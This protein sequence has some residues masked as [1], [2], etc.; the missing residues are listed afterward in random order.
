[1]HA[2]S[3]AIGT[4]ATAALMVVAGIAQ[5]QTTANGPYYAIP[6]WDQ[7]LPAAQRFIVLSNWIDTRFPSGGAAVLDR[8]TGL[9]WQRRPEIPP[10]NQG[11][12]FI[13]APSLCFGSFTGGRGGWRLPT[14]E[15]LGTLVDPKQQNPALPLGSPF[16]SIAGAFWT[17]D[18]SA[19]AST[20]VIVDF[21]AGFADDKPKS[22]TLGVWCVRGG[23]H[24][25]PDVLAN[26]PI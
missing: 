9:I 17:T 7:Q 15:E 4:I 19:S 24:V 20:G 11:V 14:P 8:E 10:P 16:Q 3:F 25:L 5:G 26:P 21:F 23:S 13:R 12:P 2:R 22:A 6:S 1:M 18:S